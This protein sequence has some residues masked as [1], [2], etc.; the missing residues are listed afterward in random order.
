MSDEQS[1]VRE[2]AE[3]PRLRED[4]FS[5]DGGELIVQWP[6]RIVGVNKEDIDAWLKLVGR[7]LE[8]AIVGM[9]GDR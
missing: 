9:G 8:R 3:R 2:A 7:K 6:E 5:L 4:V 1:E